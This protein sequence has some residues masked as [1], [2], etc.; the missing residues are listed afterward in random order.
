MLS[1][2]KNLSILK[3]YQTSLNRDLVKGINL[4]RNEKVDCFSKKIQN[5]IKKSFSK[6]IFN[7]TPDITPLYNQLANYHKFSKKNIYITQGI[8]E[9]I[10]HLLHSLV[11]KENEVIFMNE[12]YPMYEVLCKVHDVKFKKWNFNNH[13]KLDINDL[14]KLISKKTKVIFLVNPNLPIEYEFHSNEKK[15]IY[16]ICKKKNI[17]LVYD[18][19]YHYFGAKSEISKIKKSKNLIVMRTFSKAWGLPGIRLGYMAANENLCS[20]I[21]K[22]RSLVETNGFSLEIASWALKNKFI[23][24]QHIKDVKEGYKYLVK[25]FNLQ[26]E[27][28]H[29]GKKTNAILLKIKSK[30]HIESLKKYLNKKKIYIRSG[31]KKPIEDYIRISLCS[32][33]KISVFFNE[34]KKWKKQYN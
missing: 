4:D 7:T 28:Y 10:S 21:S 8:T 30:K 17:I 9:C 20:Y 33:K 5:K 27:S 15:K 1:F 31:F 2:K 25:G 12:T 22:C 19:A 16:E 29:G 14:K 26:N 34:Y 3:R 6:Q 11:K 24:N 32:K 18:E 23:L 13:F